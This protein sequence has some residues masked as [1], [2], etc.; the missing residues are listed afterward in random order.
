MALVVGASPRPTTRAPACCVFVATVANGITNEPVTD[1]EVS[2]LDVARS[3]HTNWLGEGVIADIPAGHHRVRVR[4]IGYI[5]AD[6]EVAFA[7]DTVGVFFLL[8]P[9]PQSMDTVRAV[10][11]RSSH[12]LLM[13]D[14]EVRRRMGIG[15]FLTDSVL[16]A[17]S[18]QA[19]AT[20]LER[21]IL[22]LRSVADGRVVR[23]LSC[24]GLI[25]VYI[26]GNRVSTSTY[27]L[28]AAPN[29][30]DLRFLYGADVAGVEF[31]TDVNAPVQ[32]RHQSMACGVLLIWLRY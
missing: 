16:R 21:R 12:N 10:A 11:A 7:R 13:G 14:F 27:S 15:R 6:L 22:G 31:Y 26:D 32:Y 17:D 29:E 1:A 3:A 23:R 19:L 20:I 8:S 5:E 18:T 25:D 2:I 30:T 4:R 28:H 9:R 24:D